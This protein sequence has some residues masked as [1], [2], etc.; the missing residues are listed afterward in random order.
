[1]INRNDW[2]KF[3]LS[4]RNDLFYTDEEISELLNFYYKIRKQ[5]DKELE[6]SK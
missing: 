1:M 5:Q 6:D 4:V 3:L 2:I